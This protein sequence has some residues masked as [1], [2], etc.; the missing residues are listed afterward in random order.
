MEQVE[1][2]RAADDEAVLRVEAVGMH[3]TDRR[4]IRHHRDGRAS[5]QASSHSALTMLGGAVGATFST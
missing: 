4:T 3:I 5:R 2:P 1:V